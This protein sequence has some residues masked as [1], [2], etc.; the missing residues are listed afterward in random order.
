MSHSAHAQSCARPRGQIKSKHVVRHVSE[1]NSGSEQDYE[2]EYAY[3][4]THGETVTVAIANIKTTMLIDSGSTCNII[5]TACKEE[6]VQQGVPFTAC[7]RKI[8]P[9]SSPPIRVRQLVNAN[10]MLDNGQS[11]LGEF[12]IVEGDATPLLGKATAYKL[13]IPRVGVCHVTSSDAYRHKVVDRFPK[14]C[15]DMR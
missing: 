14:T 7:H 9:Y 5:N 13:G 11:I 8:H 10:V 15:V 4:T 2:T 6:L 12:L 1:P 3:T